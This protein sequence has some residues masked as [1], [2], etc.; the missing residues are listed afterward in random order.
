[1]EGWLVGLGLGWF[2]ISPSTLAEL[3]RRIRQNTLRQQKL[4]PTGTRFMG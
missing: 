2:Y 1:M 4:S 3:D